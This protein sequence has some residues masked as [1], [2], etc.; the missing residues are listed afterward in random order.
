VFD[1]VRVVPD[2]IRRG[3]VYSD[4]VTDLGEMLELVSRGRPR[5]HRD[6]LCKEYPD[7]NFFGGRGDQDFRR[8]KIICRE[9][10][11]MVECRNWALEQGPELEGIWAGTSP[12]E[13]AKLRAA[14]SR[15]ERRADWD[16]VPAGVLDRCHPVNPDAA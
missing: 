2:L 7:V 13:R 16:D 11:V 8:A 4:E 9:C 5:W 15:V 3:R 14:P 1:S 10:R 12:A 6:A